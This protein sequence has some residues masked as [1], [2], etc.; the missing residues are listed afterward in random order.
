MEAWLAGMAFFVEPE[1]AKEIGDGGGLDYGHV[2]QREVADG[3]HSLLELAGDA[4]PLTGVVAVVGTRCELVDEQLAV[5]G[6]EH[7]NSKQTFEAHFVRDA[8]RDLLRLG[9]ECWIDGRRDD[10]PGENLVF[11][12]V[13]R[14]GEAFAS[15][16]GARATITEISFS[17]S[18][19]FSA[20]QGFLPRSAR[21]LTGL[22]FLRG[23][24]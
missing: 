23:R 11:V 8:A 10:A 18:M 9:F 15:P 7:F 2:S 24:V 19:A 20:I 21:L 22:C 17:R 14:A 16:L 3:A 6:Y 13:E 4:G 1:I 12:V 5:F